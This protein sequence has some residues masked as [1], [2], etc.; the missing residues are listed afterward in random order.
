MSCYLSVAS[1]Y[2]VVSFLGEAKASSISCAAVKQ[3]Y[4]IRLDVC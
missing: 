1:W 3:L 2:F 4:Q